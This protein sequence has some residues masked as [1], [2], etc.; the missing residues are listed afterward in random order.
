MFEAGRLYE[1]KLHPH[2]SKEE[3]RLLYSERQY[4]KDLVDE[5]RQALHTYDIQITTSPDYQQAIY[6]L[7]KI[8]EHLDIPYALSGSLA[9]SLYGMQ[10]RKQGSISLTLTAGQLHLA[11]VIYWSVRLWR[12]ASDSHHKVL[13]SLDASQHLCY[14]LTI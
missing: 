9:S 10:S 2:A 3:T 1:Q 12:L 13:G 4:K 11:S 14:P 6:P 8:F 7:A 5:L